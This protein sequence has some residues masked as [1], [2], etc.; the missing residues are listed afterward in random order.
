MSVHYLWTQMLFENLAFLISMEIISSEA[1]SILAAP[2]SRKC[3]GLCAW[4]RHRRETR[5]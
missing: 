3:E 1:G 4:L 5:P 2:L